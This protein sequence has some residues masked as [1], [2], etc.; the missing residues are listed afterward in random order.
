[1]VAKFAAE[2]QKR[3]SGSGHTNQSREKCR[4][5]L[6]WTGV[7]VAKRRRHTLTIRHATATARARGSIIWASFCVYVFSVAL[8]LR[9]DR[10]RAHR[11][12]TPA[13]AT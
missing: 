1:M 8:P 10:A 7:V 12:F 6:F 3:A 2:R 11:A 13:P 4:A 9:S 5:L